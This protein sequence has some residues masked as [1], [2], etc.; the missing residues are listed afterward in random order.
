MANP[1]PGAHHAWHSP[2]SLLMDL[3]GTSVGCEFL[4]DRESQVLFPTDVGIKTTRSAAPPRRIVETNS[5]I[6]VRILGGVREK[7]AVPTS[8]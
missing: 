5:L 7:V 2:C 3:V 6:G 1:L 4:S 8:S